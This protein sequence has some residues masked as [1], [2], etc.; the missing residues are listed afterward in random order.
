MEFAKAPHFTGAIG[1]GQFRPDWLPL[2]TA[3]YA[4]RSCA[5]AIVKKVVGPSYRPVGAVMTVVQDSGRFGNLSSGC[6]ES[7]IERQ[8]LDAIQDGQT[9]IVRYGQGSPYFD[10]VLPC[11]GGL[12][13][14]IV[15]SPNQVRLQ[16]AVQTLKQRQ[17]VQLD[18]CLETG[19]ISHGARSN[20]EDRVFHLHFNPEL[21]FLIFG[22]GP[23]TTDFASLSSAS[24]YA[25]K[26]FSPDAETLYGCSFLGD[27]AMEL[28]KKSLPSWVTGDAWTAA[29]LFFHDHDW[30]PGLLRDLLQLDLYYI[31][32]QGSLKTMQSRTRALEDLGVDPQQI[33]RVRG[34]IGL[35]PSVRDSR[36]LAISVLSEVVA[37]AP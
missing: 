25:T 16:R 32:A 27:D 3:A 21:Q 6:V 34:P 9:R 15:P 13:I 28:T 4:T 26:L 33:A 7:D 18:I 5:L 23:E 2:E 37:L 19:Q 17:S 35:I 29:V 22:T 11:G 31:G 1:N 20:D 10:I 12:E 30:E 8:A 24:G 14:L 36:T